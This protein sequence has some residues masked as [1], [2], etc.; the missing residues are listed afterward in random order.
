MKEKVKNDPV[1]MIRSSIQTGITLPTD[2]RALWLWKDGSTEE[3]LLTNH[4]F[5]SVKDSLSSKLELDGM[6]GS[7]FEDPARS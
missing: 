3:A 1:V 7:D 4:M 5:I 2:L 6:I